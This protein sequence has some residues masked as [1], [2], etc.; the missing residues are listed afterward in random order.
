MEQRVIPQRRADVRFKQFSSVM[1]VC[2]ES[3]WSK[4]NRAL[5]AIH[6]SPVIA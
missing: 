4:S 6:S 2:M 5:K 3:V 1:I